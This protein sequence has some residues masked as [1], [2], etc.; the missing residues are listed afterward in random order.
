MNK[1]AC[2]VAATL[3]GA[4]LSSLAENNPWDAPFGV[5]IGAYSADASTTLR[6]DSNS[7]RLGTQISFEGNL[8]GEQ[9]KTIP[10]LDLYWRFNPRHALEF[11]YVSLH[12]DGD[13]TL[14]GSINWGEV[15]FPVNSRLNSEFNSDILRFA[16]R[17]SPWHTDS[18]EVGFLL[19][20]HYTQMKTSLTSS[21]GSLSQE[22]SVKYPLPTIGM[23]GSWR[24]APDW[25]VGG[26]G[27]ILKVK[28]NEYDGELY[29][30]GAGVEWAFTH[31][32]IG[33]LGY[34]YYKY[35]LT[36]TKDNARGEFDYRFDGPKLYFSWNFR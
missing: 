16:Y 32:M 24:V 20:A 9:R 34:D 6:L 22:A 11:S 30:F 10:T 23:R 19:G 35:N 3:L 5:Q 27:Q 17:Y 7:G 14:T 15:T 1:L 31:E 12:R 33:G 36:S 8:N 18:M 25:R 21:T 13:S 2:A 28:I 4:P 26:F 29:N